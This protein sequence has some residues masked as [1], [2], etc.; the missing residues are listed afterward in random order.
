MGT[1]FCVVYVSVNKME[2]PGSFDTTMNFCPSIRRHMPDNG[3][4]LNKIL[5]LTAWNSATLIFSGAVNLILICV[6]LTGG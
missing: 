6:R 1:C 5:G 2:T 3:I 4:I